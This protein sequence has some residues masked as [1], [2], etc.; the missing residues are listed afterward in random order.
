MAEPGPMPILETGKETAGFTLLEVAAVIALIGVISI[1]ALPRITLSLEQ[2]EVGSVGR[3]IQ[4]DIR[5]MRNESVM[6]PATEKVVSFTQNG[7]SFTIGDHCI[8]RNFRYEF[9]F[10]LPQQAE[11]EALPSDTL[12]DARQN[13][14]DPG[15][16]ARGTVHDGGDADDNDNNGDGTEVP[17]EPSYEIHFISGELDNEVQFHWKTRSFEGSFLCKADGAVEWKYQR[18]QHRAKRK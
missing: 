15:A 2:V 6:D 10:E 9:T 1:L 17:P 11:D 14:T 18:Q 4:S 8:T 7:Y 5:Q 12:G 16:R 13:E 3:L